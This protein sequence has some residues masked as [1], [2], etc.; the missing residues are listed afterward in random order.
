MVAETLASAMI[1]AGVVSGMQLD[2]NISNVTC[3]IYTP[4]RNEKGELT[5]PAERF[6]EGLILKKGLFLKPHT[7]DFFYVTRK[8]GY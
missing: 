3:E 2:M 8:K 6:C 5:V 1:Q 4:S 7:R